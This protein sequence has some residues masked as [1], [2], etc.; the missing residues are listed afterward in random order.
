VQPVERADMAMPARFSLLELT[1]EGGRSCREFDSAGLIA[2]SRLY[3]RYGLA[4]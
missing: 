2:D 3:S 4:R 1:L